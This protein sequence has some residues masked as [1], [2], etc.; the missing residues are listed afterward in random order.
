MAKLEIDYIAETDTD[1]AFLRFRQEG[2]PGYTLPLSYLPE[3]VEALEQESSDVH[4]FLMN[5]GVQHSSSS[6]KLCVSTSER[7]LLQLDKGQ[8]AKLIDHLRREYATAL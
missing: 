4:Y 1:W 7:P 5:Y 8:C 2:F 6:T 3:F